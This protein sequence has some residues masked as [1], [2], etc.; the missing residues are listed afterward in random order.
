MVAKAEL[1]RVFPQKHHLGGVTS[2]YLVGVHD[3]VVL[4]VYIHLRE[5]QFSVPYMPLAVTLRTRIFH[6]TLNVEHSLSVAAAY[7]RHAVLPRQ[8]ET[9]LS[10]Y[11][12]GAKH[13]VAQS[14]C[15]LRHHLAV[16]RLILLRHRQHVI[17]PRAEQLADVQ[18][19]V[20]LPVAV[21]AQYHA[22]LVAHLR[23][24]ENAVVAHSVEDVYVLRVLTR[25]RQKHQHRVR[26][27]HRGKTVDGAVTLRLF[28]FVYAHNIRLA[29][30]TC[31]Q[32]QRQ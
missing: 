2:Q 23:Q 25:L 14:Q 6:R 7:H 24:A 28:H 27:P 12:I 17:H 9:I 3:A 21:L 1:Q 16:G 4:Y 8:R 15:G 5:H 19:H 31:R 10:R 30:A 11:H 18:H 29:S 26:A 22:H 20:G 32:H 13:R